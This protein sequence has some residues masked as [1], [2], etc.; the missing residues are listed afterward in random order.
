MLLFTFALLFHLF[1][2]A[3]KGGRN[4]NPI[5]LTQREVSER[6]GL[7]CM[8]SMW[9]V[10]VPKLRACPQAQGLFLEPVTHTP[11]GSTH[12]SSMLPEGCLG[13]K[14]SLLTGELGAVLSSK[15]HPCASVSLPV[16]GK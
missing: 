11:P 6:D 15:P 8:G 12:H 5:T 3:M 10:L 16:M 1:Q 7:P 9:T 13:P 14:N 4:M 2:Q